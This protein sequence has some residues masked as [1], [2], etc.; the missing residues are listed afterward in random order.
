VGSVV[1]SPAGAVVVSSPAGAVVVTSAVGVVSTA[2]T[3]LKFVVVDRIGLD[4]LNLDAVLVWL[5]ISR[6][7]LEGPLV[8]AVTLLDNYIARD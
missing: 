2:S 5:E 4:T 6:V 3:R 7:D 1:S 8:R